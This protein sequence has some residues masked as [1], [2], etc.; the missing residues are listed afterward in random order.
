MHFNI[1]HLPKPRLGSY[2]QGFRCAIFSAIMRA[3][4]AVGLI[5]LDFITVLLCRVVWLKGHRRFGGF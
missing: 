5:V 3:T 1:I 4:Y 2:L